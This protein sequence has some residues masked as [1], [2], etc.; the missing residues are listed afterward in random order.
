MKWSD[1]M[2]KLQNQNPNKVVLMK[3]GIFF[4]AIG[5]DAILLNKLLELKLTCFSSKIC[6]VGFP[7]K[8]YDKYINLLKNKN[9]SFILF[10]YNKDTKHE[11]KIYEFIGED[12]TNTFTNNNCLT[13]KNK[14]D[15]TNEIIEKIKNME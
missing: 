8:N 1:I 15:T 11:E 5:K 14:K 10:D 13:C 12:I 3:N 2:Q 4:T 6:K 9:I 7:I